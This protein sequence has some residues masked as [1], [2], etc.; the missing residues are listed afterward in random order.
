MFSLST[1][2]LS[3]ALVA[4]LVFAKDGF[5]YRSR[6]QE[7]HSGSNSTILQTRKTWTLADKYE[8]QAF[9]D[10]WNF[11]EWGDPTHGRVNY[12]NKENAQN[13]GLA[14]VQGDGKFVMA[15]D[16]KNWVGVG[17]NRDSVRIGSQKS[18]TQ[19]LFIADLQAMPF[20]CSVWPAWW[21][22]G[23]NWPN[24]G[25]IDVLEG[26]HNQRVNQ[27]T[28]HT[29]P[30]CTIDT[31]V[32]ATG[33]IGNQQCAVG[34]NDNTGCFFT[35]T[36]DNSYGQPFNAAG[37][38]VFAHTWQDDGIKIWHFARD[39]IPG[40][41]SSGNPNPDGWGEPVAYFSSN[42]CDIGSHFYEHGL[43]FDITLCG[44]WAGATYSQAGCP[45]SCDERVANP[46][47]FHDAKFIV[48]Y[49]AVYQ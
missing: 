42:T 16:D 4:Q 24:G 15:V 28:L 36:N 12:Q 22:V 44:D 7:H 21:S 37:G 39:S 40:D 30:G 43:T 38:G 5:V 6:P 17:S 46:D 26:V 10:Q 27:Y 20:G 41:I 31:S 8:G 29:S 3:L 49:V 23:P 11:F 18:Y 2:L 48:N 34:G 1:G 13:K 45:G 47:N 25:E 35:D 33:Q 19:G 32:Q 9:F 14:Y